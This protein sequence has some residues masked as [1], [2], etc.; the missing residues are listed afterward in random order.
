MRECCS[1]AYRAFLLC[2]RRARRFHFIH[3]LQWSASRAELVHINRDV[4]KELGSLKVSKHLHQ[5]GEPGLLIPSHSVME[6]VQTK[7]P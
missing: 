1:V 5:G 7:S 4:G 2:I 6:T 3:H